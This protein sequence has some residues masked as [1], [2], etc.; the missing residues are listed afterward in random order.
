MY[1]SERH[2]IRDFTYCP[3]Y[4]RCPYL[5]GVRIS[6]V[7]VERGSTVYI[8]VDKYRLPLICQFV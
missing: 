7:S 2:F 1:V 3:Q 4:R 8:Y 6:G 5:R